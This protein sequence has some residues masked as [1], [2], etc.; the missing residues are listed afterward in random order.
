LRE[1]QQKEYNLPTNTSSAGS[2]LEAELIKYSNRVVVL[3]S[4]DGRRISLPINKLAPTDQV[5]VTK[6]NAENTK[7]TGGF[8]SASKQQAIK[9]QLKPGLAEMLPSK[10]LDS[11]GKKISQDELAGKTVGFYFSAHWCP[12]CRAFTPSLV[13]FRDSNKKDFEVVF[14]SSD[15]S[16]DAQMGY[17]K[18]TDMKWYTLELGS[19]EGNA[20]KQKFGIRGTPALII[21]SPDGEIIIKNGRGDVSSNASGAIK[22]WTKS[23]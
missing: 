20:L 23:S 4:A 8:A 9:A 2:K 5:M 6:W 12:P 22:A 11:S 15:R 19:Q 13:K 16:S 18:E 17:M 3:R 10:L 1:N 7:S 21:V 14:V